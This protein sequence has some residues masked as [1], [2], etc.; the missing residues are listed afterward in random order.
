MTLGATGEGMVA[1]DAVNTAARLQS[2]GRTG[3]GAGR[4]GDPARSRR[5]RSPTRTPGPHL[6]KGKAGPVALWRAMRVLVGA[7][8]AL[9]SSR[10]SKLRSSVGTASCGW[11]KTSSARAR[12][13]AS[14]SWSRSPGIAGIGKSR[15]VWEFFKYIDG[16]AADRVWHRGRCLSYG[17]GVTFWALAEMVRMRARHRRGRGAGVGARQA[18]R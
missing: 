16:L 15:L 11:S 13:R 7:R 18:R 1:G 5:R 4:R 2:V 10:A 17:E 12:T 14:R 9:Q 6:L 8:G 3:S